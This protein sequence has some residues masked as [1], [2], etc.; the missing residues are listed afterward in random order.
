MSRL[1][2]VK[3]AGYYPTPA[4]V[5]ALIV[6]HLKAPEGGYRWLDPC[7][8]E[9][10]ALK[11]LAQALDGQTY[12]IELDAERAEEATSKLDH[13]RQGDYAAHR[14]PK[15]NKAGISALFL[16]PPYDQDDRAG[17][18][19]ELAFLRETQEWL[20]AGGVLIYLIP[21]HRITSHIAARLP[22]GG[23]LR[24]QAAQPATR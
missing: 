21:Q 9:G 13:V 14:L 10:T 1:E 7:C 4:Q 15:R 12:G 3:K 5:T 22:P 8:G 24:R 11:S 20:M 16:N 2:S 19:L 23:H 18:R 6:G 17:K